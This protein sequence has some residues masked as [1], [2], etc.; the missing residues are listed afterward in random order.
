MFERA[1]PR[2]RRGMASVVQ[3]RGKQT[4]Q[5]GKVIIMVRLE[6]ETDR[7]TVYL[8][9]EIDHHTA[10]AVRE[11]VDANLQRSL[12]KQLVL[13]F[14]DVTFMDSS[15]VGLIMGRYK[16]VKSMGGEIVIRNAREQIAK[17]MRLAGLDK[18]AE[19]EGDD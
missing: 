14:R 13:D 16:L 18:L 19:I 9:G 4:K 17:L 8:Y 12:P 10:R 6:N 2:L 7:L 5:K 3:N 1:I 15:G 11:E